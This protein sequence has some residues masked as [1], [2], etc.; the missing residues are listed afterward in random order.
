VTNVYLDTETCGL[1]GPAVILQYAFDDGPIIIH[2]FWKE[3]IKKSLELLDKICEHCVVGFNLT[4]DW[5]Q[6]I[7]IYN[8]FLLAE[9]KDLPPE[10]TD[11]D[12]WAYR[13]K[14]A[15]KGPCLKPRSAL[16]LMLHARKTKYQVTMERNDIRIRRV[17]TALAFKLADELEQR[18]VLQNILFARRK[19]DTAPKWA[20]YNIE[21]A[22]GRIDPNF[23]DVVLKFKPSTALKALAQDALGVKEDAILLFSEVEVD[24]KFWPKEL[25]YAPYALAVGSPGNWK[26]AWP[27]VIE[28]HIAHWSSNELARRYANNDIVYTRGLWDHFGRPEGGDDDSTLACGIAA[29]RFRGYAVDI[30]AIKERKAEEQAKLGK[31]PLAPRRAKEMLLS[32]LSPAELAIAKLNR[33]TGKVILEEIA[34]WDN[35]DCPFGPCE[36]CNNTGK[37]KHPASEVAKGI[38]E[39]RKAVKR[40]ELYDKL[41]HAGRL[42]ASFKVIGTLSS[43]MSGTDGLNPQG[44]PREKVVRKC[45]PFADDGLVL[46]GGDF[47]GFEVTLADAAYNDT[48]LREDLL[49]MGICPG[50]KGSGQS[51]NNVCGDC[52][53]KGQT[54]QKIHALFAMGLAPGKSYAD[55]VATKGAKDG[56]DLYDMGKRGVFALMYG[57]NANTLVTKL[58]VSLEIALKAEAAFAA[59]YPNV[60]KSRKAIFDMFCSMRQDGGIGS[61]VVWNEP[62]EYIESLLGF[63]RYFTLENNICRVL[64]EMANNPPKDWRK[65][66]IKVVRRDRE[67]TASGALQ[68]SLYAAAFGIQ[69]SNMR[70]AANHVIQSSG[71][72]ITKKVQRSIWDLQPIGSHKWCVQPMNIHDEILCPTHPD[73]I[74]KVKD[75][76][77][78]TVES[79]RER[80]PLIEIGWARMNTWADK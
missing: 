43:R 10:F 57:G 75:T 68:S 67:Q 45:F 9:E 31:Y 74:D 4:F 72:Q 58:G 25:L 54:K 33:G 50:C 47:E 69:S 18:V 14:D 1:T 20:V 35:A 48:K 24:K 77:N 22:D 39:S 66:N 65:I 59:R 56:L 41:I 52:G 2:E 7:K 63:K 42:H 21:R 15:I 38:L 62:S 44:I 71:A 17:P 12:S 80:V 8:M 26:G 76:V 60:G 73:Y 34:N 78:N 16:D 29:C 28:R 46:T 11:F 36:E 61:R 37:L 13:E 40:I 70:A 51:K 64:F 53:G 3:P 49:T 32:Y 79:F 27:E 6:L 19:N 23:K 30:N 5:F 55:I